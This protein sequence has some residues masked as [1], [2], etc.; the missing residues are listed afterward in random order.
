[1]K[2][3]ILGA[4]CAAA[5]VAASSTS[6]AVSICVQGTWASTLQGRDLDGNPTTVEAYYARP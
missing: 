3:T 2:Q 1:M 4:V 6:Q 5:L